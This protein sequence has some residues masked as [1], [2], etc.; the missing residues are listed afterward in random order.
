MS[1]PTS[2]TSN[3]DRDDLLTRLQVTASQLQE[4][5]RVGYLAKSTATAAEPAAAG[6]SY[7]YFKGTAQL[8]YTLA[9][10]GWTFDSIRNF[11]RTLRSDRRVAIA[12]SSGDSATGLAHAT[13]HTKNPKG[14]MMRRAVEANQQIAMFEPGTLRPIKYAEIDE[15]PIDDSADIETWLLLHW[16]DPETLEIRLELALPTGMGESQITSW[17]H[18][19]LLPSISLAPTFGFGED[20]DEDDQ[21]DSLDVDVR[22]RF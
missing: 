8:R 10:E 11:E 5:I 20:I 13:P 14:P 7:V 6:P 3:D 15:A 12:L 18:R 16:Q 21:D 4:V 17:K 19:I 1:I 9:P 22:P 2:I